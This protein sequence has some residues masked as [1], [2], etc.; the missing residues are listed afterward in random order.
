MVFNEDVSTRFIGGGFVY[1]DGQWKANSFTFN[2]SSDQFHD[3]TKDMHATE[4]DIISG[5]LRKFYITHS[6]TRCPNVC[7]ERIL[8]SSDKQNAFDVLE[9]KNDKRQKNCFGRYVIAG[10]SLIN[11]P[12]EIPNPLRAPTPI[13]KSYC[14]GPLEDHCACCDGRCEPADGCNCSGCMLLDLQMHRNKFDI[15]Q[16][17]YINKRGYITQRHPEDYTKFY[18]GFKI[19]END[20]NSWDFCWPN[21]GG[22]C[23]GCSSFNELVATRY[24]WIWERNAVLF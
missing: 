10:R 17:S 7:V 21:N 6:C 2:A 5:A 8:R 4:K 24:A 9:P 15:R 20:L 16:E 3:K 22:Q 11:N 19:D 18:C 13:I 23:A 1:Q 12:F 14:G